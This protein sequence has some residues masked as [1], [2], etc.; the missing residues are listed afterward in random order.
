MKVENGYE[1][2]AEQLVAAL[3]QS[4]A[5][6]GKERHATGNAPFM[7]QPIITMGRMCGPGGAAQQVMKK[8]QE[9]LGMAQR[10]DHDA[11][12]R[13]LHGAIVYA[14]ACAILIDEKRANLL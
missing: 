7:E 14:A 3:N 11:A 2:L 10:G 12:I 5:G 1:P 13:E 6:K 8:T 9:A 4:Q